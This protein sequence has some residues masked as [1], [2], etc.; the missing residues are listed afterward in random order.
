LILISAPLLRNDLI[1][2]LTASEYLKWEQ[3]DFLLLLL[4]TRTKA[5][6]LDKCPIDPNED[7]YDFAQFLLE[8]VSKAPNLEHLSFSSNYQPPYVDH[9]FPNYVKKIIVNTM[10][11]LKNLQHLNMYGYFGLTS[12]NLIRLTKN[13]KNLVCLK[14][15]LV[16]VFLI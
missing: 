1:D 6:V 2:H 7:I 15:K 16:I 4:N 8:V 12:E 5:L 14:V 11:L 3:R 9:L 10:A 13:L